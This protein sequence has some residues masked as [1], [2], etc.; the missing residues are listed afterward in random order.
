[1]SGYSVLFITAKA[2][3]N[4]LNVVLYVLTLKGKL[5]AKRAVFLLTS[6]TYKYIVH[7]VRKILAFILI[8]F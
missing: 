2:L 7:L 4:V 3:I 6:E 5:R 8:F 1:M